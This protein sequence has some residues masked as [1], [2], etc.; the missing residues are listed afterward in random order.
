MEES[1]KGPGSVMEGVEFL[2][3]YDI[4]INPRCK[5]TIYE[6]SHYQ[7]EVDKNTG[8]IKPKQPLDKDNHIID[9]LRYSLEA[10]RNKK[11]YTVIT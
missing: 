2:Q 7:F 3:N 8:R 1:R 5:N 6:L 9:G 11:N 10:Y 4:I